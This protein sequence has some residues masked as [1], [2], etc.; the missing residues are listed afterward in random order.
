MGV[1]NVSDASQAFEISRATD[2]SQSD[3]LV[4]G[5]EIEIPPGPEIL[6]AFAFP[7][8]ADGYWAHNPQTSTCTNYNAGFGGAP[9]S[10]IISNG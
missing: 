1:M 9:P 3:S 5:L 6:D 2:P 4:Q 7:E 8:Y 10:M